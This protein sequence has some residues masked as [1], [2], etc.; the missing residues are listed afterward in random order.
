MSVYMNRRKRPAREPI[1]Q[2]Q[3]PRP[4]PEDVAIYRTVRNDPEVQALPA[5]SRSRLLQ[6]IMQDGLAVTIDKM[7]MAPGT[8]NAAA[9]AILER[10]ERGGSAEGLVTKPAK[11]P[12][13]RP[14]LT[15][16]LVRSELTHALDK[17][18]QQNVSPSWDAI[19]AQHE[20]RTVFG[21]TTSAL[22]K[23]KDRFPAVFRELL[24]HLFPEE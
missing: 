9:I 11:R 20:G 1:E 2:A 23:R 7:K 17:L 14:R 4:T 21:L 3:A 5:R 12:P 16:A 22:T 18:A 8:G 13:G 24:P 10:I 6:W 19:A 15:E